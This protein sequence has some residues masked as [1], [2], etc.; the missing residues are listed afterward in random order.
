[1][2]K[3]DGHRLADYL[4]DRCDQITHIVSD[5][6]QIRDPH[7]E[8]VAYKERLATERDVLEALKRD[9]FFDKFASDDES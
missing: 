2:N 3:V 6:C 7:P 1:M 4:S 5:L 9:V 8:I